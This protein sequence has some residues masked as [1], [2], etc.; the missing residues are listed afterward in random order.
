MSLK[1]AVKEH[2]YE[3]D[4]FFN[5]AYNA[6]I[7]TEDAKRQ[8]VEHAYAIEEQ[9]LCCNI[10]KAIKFLQSLKAQGYTEIEQ[11]WLGYEDNYFVAIKKEEETD[12]EYYIRLGRLVEGYAQHIEQQEDLKLKKENS[13]KELEEELRQLKMNRK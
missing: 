9:D 1:K 11:R 2:Y 10:D 13:I 12:D 7:K 6:I 8:I 4:K 5:K 3:E